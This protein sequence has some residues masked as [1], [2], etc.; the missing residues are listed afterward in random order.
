MQPRL[1]A[2]AGAFALGLAATPLAAQDAD[3]VVATVGGTEITIG[4]MIVARQ[5]L[6]RQYQQLPDEVLFPGLLDQLIQQNAL[7]QS[8]EDPTKATQLTIENQRTGLLAGEALGMAGQDA[9]TEE[10][11][12]TAY[13]DRYAEAEPSTEYNASHILVETEEEAQSL[14]GQIDEG[15]DFAEL[16]REHSTGP[17]GPDGG[18]LGWFG[19]GMMVPEFEEAVM[20]LEAGE[21]SPPVQTQFGW[22][23]VKLNETRMADAPPLEEVRA[24]I[25][26]EL[27][28][29][30]VEARIAEVVEQA[31][32]TRAEIDVDPAILSDLS[33]VA[34]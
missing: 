1:V 33:L 20:A 31:D 34:E 26:E 6:P 2:L 13:E 21:V 23:V 22:H 12:E 10:A 3:T 25:A 30:A 9:V 17:S 8:L 29:Q 11:I 7:A 18:A 19:A 32:I 16:A 28:Q 14:I 5:T 27:R 15:A 24:E 4:H